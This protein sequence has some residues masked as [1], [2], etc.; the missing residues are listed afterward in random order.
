VSIKSGTL[1]IDMLGFDAL[2]LHAKL[3]VAAEAA[4]G[5]ESS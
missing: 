4:A 5:Q 2:F 3:A 1:Q